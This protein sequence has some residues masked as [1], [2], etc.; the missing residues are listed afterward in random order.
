MKKTDTEN[1][2]DVLTNKIHHTQEL[3]EVSLTLETIALDRHFKTHAANIVNDSELNISQKKRQLTYLLGTIDN[4]V[5]HDFFCDEVNA[6][7]FWFFDNQKIDYLDEFVKQFQ[8]TTETIHILHLTTA[9]N[10]SPK[11]IRSISQDLSHEFSSKIIVDH[12][13]NTSL[14][15]GVLVKLDNYIFDYSLRSKFQQFQREWLS[16]LDKTSKLVGRFD[17]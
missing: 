6:G 13:V 3:K 2:C 11:Q 4:Q 9:V 17:T 14:I 7:N 16:S 15:G 10:L 12:T 5:I 1:L 8:Q